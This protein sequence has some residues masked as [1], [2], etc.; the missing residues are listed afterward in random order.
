MLNKLKEVVANIKNA[1]LSRTETVPL[2]LVVIFEKDDKV[3]LGKLL[4][5]MRADQISFDFER[6][7]VES[8]DEAE[9]AVRESSTESEQLYYALKYI[10]LFHKVTRRTIDAVI[11]DNL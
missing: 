7:S 1:Q 10:S 8:V 9:S 6:K 2:D 4:L 11:K 3:Q 5:Q